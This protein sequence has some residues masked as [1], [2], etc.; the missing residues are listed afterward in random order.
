VSFS[1]NQ[2]ETL[3]A[4]VAQTICEQLTH[5]SRFDRRTTKFYPKLAQPWEKPGCHSQLDPSA[6]RNPTDEG[7]SEIVPTALDIGLSLSILD[8]SATTHQTSNQNQRRC[9]TYPALDTV[10]VFQVS[11]SDGS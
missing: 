8:S 10:S 6:Y 4:C 9:V 5:D 2:E 7:L 11:Y 1:H 3:M